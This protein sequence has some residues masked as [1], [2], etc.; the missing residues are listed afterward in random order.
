[1]S[2]F[3]KESILQL[4]QAEDVFLLEGIQSLWSGYG[5]IARYGLVNSKQAQVVV[6]HVQLPQQSHHP[7]GWNTGLS[8]ALLNV[9]NGHRSSAQHQI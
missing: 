5:S 6:K 4:T 2:P 9:S 7:R 8:N 1:M 3:L